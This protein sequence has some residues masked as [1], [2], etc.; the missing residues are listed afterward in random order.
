LPI[1]NDEQRK[2]VSKR[3]SGRE[4]TEPRMKSFLRSVHFRYILIPSLVLSVV[5][6][7]SATAPNSWVVSDL[8]HFYFELFAVILSTIVAFYCITRAY[9]LNER[10]S[11]YVGIGFSTIAVIDLLH[12]LFSYIA[13]GNNQFLSYFIPQTWFAGR[14][15]LGAMLVIAVAKYAPKLE[16]RDKRQIEQAERNPQSEGILNEKSNSR[17]YDSIYGV[18]NNSSTNDDEK[19]NFDSTNN[20]HI[21]Q[22]EGKL[23]RSLLLSLFVLSFLAVSVVVISFFTIFPGIVLPQSYARPYENPALILFS[24]ALF[25]FYKKKLYKSNDAFYK[26]ILGALIIDVFGQI[27][28][29]YA[30]TNFQ[31]AHNVAHILK[32]S[33]YF[34]IILSLAVSSIQYNKI[35]TQREATIR[36]QYN[37][38]KEMDKMKDE[39]INV[40]AH[41]LR[42]PIQPIIGLSEI[43]RSRIRNNYGENHSDSNA[44]NQEFVDVILRNGQRLGKLVEDVLDVTKIESQ[45]LELHKERF[46]L[47]ELIISIIDDIMAAEAESMVYGLPARRKGKNN[48]KI[49]YQPRPLHVHA[50]RNR[51]AQV[52]S[53]LLNNAL[54]F[55]SEGYVMITAEKKRDKN[56]NTHDVA[57]ISVCDSGS[58]VDP[59]IMP[60]LFTKFSS[61]S[62][63]GTGLGLYICKKIIEAHGGRIWAENNKDANGATFSFTLPIVN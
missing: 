61:K 39:F 5:T 52:I 27:I 38:L 12:A 8:D 15:F 45:S 7:F 21:E 53:N 3:I 13:V 32:N 17:K 60:R 1:D 2:K 10:F 31:T 54:K 36:L 18:Q 14:T 35:A 11:L 47:N 24:I 37:K 41:E 55:T 34:I 50:D 4:V 33:G 44:E 42:T 28:M 58:G 56:S 19:N 49:T 59:E 43:L 63:S 48:V 26:G 46:D 30:S 29:S 51:I 57:I 40:A 20:Q 6:F 62:F 23:H 9:T 22:E 16:R 25:L